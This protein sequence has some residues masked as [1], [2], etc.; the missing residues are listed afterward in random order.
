MPNLFEL[1]IRPAQA[2][3]KRIAKQCGQFAQQRHRAYNELLCSLAARVHIQ[4]S[5]INSF[6]MANVLCKVMQGA[7]EV[8]VT[9]KTYRI[10]R[11]DLRNLVCLS[12]CY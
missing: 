8:Y 10:T 7:V 4:H 9:F 1:M 2:V 12:V 5:R 3:N 6:E 11:N